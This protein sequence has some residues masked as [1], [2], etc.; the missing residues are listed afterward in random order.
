MEPP[1]DPRGDRVDPLR[2][3]YLEPLAAAA[4]MAGSVR[5]VDQ[6][7]DDRVPRGGGCQPAE[8]VRLVQ[9]RVHEVGS[10]TTQTGDRSF[11]PLRSTRAADRN[12]LRARVRERLL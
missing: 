8:D 4:E 3:P 11:E 5:V 6:T 9:G 12:E 2:R 7:R 10:P 1:R